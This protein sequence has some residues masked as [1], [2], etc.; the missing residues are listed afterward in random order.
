L[1]KEFAESLCVTLPFWKAEEVKYKARE[2][3][4]P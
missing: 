2:R 1:S 3:P 4:T